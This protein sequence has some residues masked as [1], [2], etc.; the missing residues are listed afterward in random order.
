MH[1]I[2]QRLSELVVTQGW[3]A[4]FKSALQDVAQQNVP[5]L[6]A[7]QTFDDYLNYLDEMVGWAPRESGDSRLVHDKLVEFYF[8]LDQP[9]LRALQSPIA[10]G[11]SG[12]PLTPLSIWIVDFA[13]AWGS[14]LDEGES[15]KHIDSFRTDPAFCWDDYMLPPSGYRTFNQFFARHVKPGRRPIAALDDAAVI[16]SPADASFMGLW[17]I[18][19]DSTLMIEAPLIEAKGL[20]WS[21]AELLAGSQYADRFAGGIFSH[22]ALRTFD[23]HR[24][25]SPVSGTVLETR[26]IQG[27]AYLDVDVIESVG[28]PGESPKRQLH[29]VE[30]T[31]YQ[32]VQTRGLVVLDS[33][34][35]LVACLPV[36]M[37]QVSSVVLTAEVGAVLRKGEELGYFQFGGSDFV[38]VFERSSQI[39]IACRVD[40]HFLQ[41]QE[42]ARSRRPRTT[43]KIENR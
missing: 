35:G 2:V 1:P 9:A 19:A 43:L 26:I 25:H 31:G 15:A 41:G 37:A 8:V 18:D 14:Y 11:G 38:M 3:E 20:R 42:I 4:P 39:E 28:K 24:F 12:Q 22:V 21:I 6:A 30:G 27:Q 23:Y 7:L 13:K 34:I 36:G 33:P 40:E 17:P 10:P 5:A 32:F 16:V 29:A